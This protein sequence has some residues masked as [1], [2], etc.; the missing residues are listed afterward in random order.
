MKDC[1]L[2]QKYF[3]HLM[4]VEDINYRN[5]IEN[6]LIGIAKGVG[7]SFESS[8]N[9]MRQSNNFRDKMKEKQRKRKKE[10]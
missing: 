3:L 9:D 5:S 10:V 1:T 7:I 6:K 2:Q 8:T 4:A